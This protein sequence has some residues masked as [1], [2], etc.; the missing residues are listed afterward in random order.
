MRSLV[1]TLCLLAVACSDEDAADTSAA[2]GDAVTSTGAPEPT[3]TGSVDTDTSTTAPPDPTI[4]PGGC[5]DG[6][7]DPGESCDLAGSNSDHGD[8]TTYC[9]FAA[10]GD[11]LVHAGIEECDDGNPFNND[12]CLVDCRLPRCGDGTVQPGEACDDANTIDDDACPTD[13]GLADCGDGVVQ[14]G[15]A[16][17][18]GNIV[19]TDDCLNTCELATCGDGIVHAGAETC[20][21]GNA[22]DN[23]ACTV[24]CTPPSCSDGLHNG[25]ESD[26]DCGGVYC[27]GCALGQACAGNLDCI[28]GI[29]VQGACSPPIPL[30]PPDCPPADVDHLAAWSQ[31]QPSC[32]CHHNGAGN[33]K[34][35]SADSFRASTVNVAPQTAAIDLVTPG[36]IGQSYLIFKILNQ[37]SSVAGGRGSRMPIAKSLSDGQICTLINWV[38]SGAD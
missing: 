15:E 20:D 13:C 3:D 19:F 2:T 27:D 24:A 7:I 8:C 29:C 38:R 21:D 31:I 10:C 16:C 4:P 33:L 25:F 9:R 28:D 23:D 26:L 35:N 34:F 11:G 32:G 5:G 37:Q 12:G 1:A 6:V 18:D 17:D 36:E 14:P 22:S 30:M